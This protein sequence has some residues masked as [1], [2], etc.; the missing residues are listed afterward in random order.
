MSIAEFCTKRVV[1]AL[2]SDTVFNAAR[3]MQEKN[4]GSI[5]VFD[6]DKKPIGMVTDRDIAVKVIAEGKDPK[7]TFLREIMSEETT[8]LHQ[9]QGIFD[10]TKLMNEKGIRR[11]PVVDAD[12]KLSGIISLDDLIMMFGV[13]VANIAAAIAYGTSRPATIKLPFADRFTCD[14]E[15]QTQ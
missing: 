5:V 8:V 13:E 10:A 3:Q 6:A 15:L 9:N 7:T 2:G 11:I 14:W 12:G 4:V 1:T